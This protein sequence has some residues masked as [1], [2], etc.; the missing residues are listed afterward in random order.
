MSK[1]SFIEE[2]LARE[3]RMRSKSQT[4]SLTQRLRE[5]FKVVSPDKDSL[6]YKIELVK[7]AE[8]YGLILTPNEVRVIYGYPTISDEPQQCVLEETTVAE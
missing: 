4:P 8:R 1:K 7:N 5:A 3:G 2:E 6:A